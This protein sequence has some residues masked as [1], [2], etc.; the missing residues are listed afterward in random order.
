MTIRRPTATLWSLQDMV[1][2]LIYVRD[3][4]KVLGTQLLST[5]DFHGITAASRMLVDDD[6]EIAVSK[7]WLVEPYRITCDTVKAAYALREEMPE[8]PQWIE[9][10]VDDIYGEDDL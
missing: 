4:R 8:C 10:T 7:L 6:K 9:F 5:A 3:G 2:H 1:E